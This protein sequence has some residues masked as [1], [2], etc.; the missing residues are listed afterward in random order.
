[1]VLWVLV[2]LLLLPSTDADYTQCNFTSVI[3]H[4]GFGQPRKTFQQ[5]YYVLNNDCNLSATTRQAMLVYTGN[6]G[7][8]EGFIDNSRFLETVAASLSADLVFIEHRYYG[9]SQP[10]D[11][12]HYQH[13]SSTQALADFAGII[14]RLQSTPR[15]VVAA[16]GSYGG[17]LAAWLRVKYPSL[18]DAAYAAS[19]PLQGGSLQR[20]TANPSLKTQLYQV[21]ANAM[22]PSCQSVSSLPSLAPATCWS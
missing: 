10:I 13:L 19:A 9:T 7:P 12:V 3:D 14:T 5:K 18:V 16:G 1:M 22:P 6:E 11:T 8:I 17:M 20:Y 15:F 4:F 21:V 2:A